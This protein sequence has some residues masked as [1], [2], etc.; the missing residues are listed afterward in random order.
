MFTIL[1]GFLLSSVV[2]MAKLLW[3]F[4]VLGMWAVVVSG[5]GHSHA[6]A[7]SPSVDC[8]M[9]LLSMADCLSFVMNASTVS[10]PE[11]SCCSGFKTVLKETPKC[12]CEAFNNKNNLGVTLNMTRA[13]TLPSACGVSTPPLSKCGSK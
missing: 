11:G 3:A 1:F 13:T 12:L 9:V 5:G 6:H 4:C 7:P 8:S 2:A 10:K